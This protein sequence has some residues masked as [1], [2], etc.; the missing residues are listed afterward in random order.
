MTKIQNPILKGENRIREMG[1]RKKVSQLVERK[2]EEARRAV[3]GWEASSHF[4]SGVGRA[5]MA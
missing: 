1:N 2:E 5:L 3:C 4:E